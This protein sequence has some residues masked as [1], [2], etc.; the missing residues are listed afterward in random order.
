M[1]ATTQEAYQLFHDGALALARAEYNGIKVDLPYC[2]E[3]DKHLQNREEAMQ[4][5]LKESE[6]Y[7]LWGKMMP[8]TEI[9]LDSTKQLGKVLF[10][11][12]EIPPPIITDKGNYSVSEEALSIVAPEVPGVQHILD[13]RGI[14][15]ARSTYFGGILKEQFDGVLHP[16]FHL[17]K[18]KT[19]RSSSSRINFQN[20]PKRDPFMM[21]MIRKAFS[22]RPGHRLVEVDFGGIE[23]KVSACCHKDP[24]ML[25]YIRDPSTDMHRD[26]SQDAFFLSLEDMTPDNEDQEKD[27]GNIRYV[28]KNGFTFAQFYGDYFGNCAR[29]M[30]NYIDSMN[31][32]TKQGVGL[33]DHLAK[34]GVHNLEDFKDHLRGVE[35]IFWNVRF[36]KYSAW[37]KKTFKKY[38]DTGYVDLLTGFRCGGIPL[39]KNQVL[40]TPI[41][42]PAFHCLLW[43][44]IETDKELRR[45]NMKSLILGQ[46]HDAI[47]LDVL[48][49]EFDNVLDLLLNIMCK[50]LRK[51]WKWIIVPMEVTV[52]ASPVDGNWSELKKLKLN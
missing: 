43:S 52:E 11:V 19:Y 14:Q 9:N 44:L 6:L 41:Q 45:N 35:D 27:I 3:T 34:H 36:K 40:N 20:L 2:K 42:G 1:R 5:L 37:K 49:S 28:G 24:N 4:S 38:L 32:V 48:D 47:V 16:F 21:N 39:E 23:V 50:R 30:W 26:V 33:Y 25:K 31:L 10:E 46:I 13:I 7:Q 15:K 17:N 51:Y 22:A 12:M 8:P 29:I 18:V